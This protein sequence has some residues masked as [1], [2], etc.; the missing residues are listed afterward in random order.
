[1][2]VCSQHLY[3][4]TEYPSPTDAGHCTHLRSLVTILIQFTL[5][6]SRNIHG[7]ARRST[8]EGFT[9]L[10]TIVSIMIVGIVVV[11]FS[12]GSNTF[13][14]TRDAKQQ[15]IAAHIAS[16]KL[17]LVRE[18][19]YAALPSDGPFADPLLSALPYGAAS[20]SV[21]VVNAKTKQVDVIV[22]WKRGET[23]RSVTLTTLI[24]ETGGL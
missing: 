10:E 14:L 5:K 15:D 21:T 3:G 11:I 19:G 13:I 17:A 7:L 12:T 4:N 9:L 6:Y 16:S 18:N 2:S 1:M 24:T 22:G 8:A 23:Q 20:T